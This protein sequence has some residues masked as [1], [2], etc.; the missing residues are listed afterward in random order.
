[1]EKKTTCTKCG[2]SI[3]LH[4]A[5]QYDRLCQACSD[6]PAL[7]SEGLERPAGR[8]LDGQ[9]IRIEKNGESKEYADFVFCTD[10]RDKD[11]RYRSRSMRVGENRGLLR[12][13]KDNGAIEILY[14]MHED[15]D[16]LILSR[17]ALVLL[18]HWKSGEYPDETSFQ[19]G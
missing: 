10:V 2:C 9:Y 13:Y 11:P 8:N 6:R 14:P 7:N 1:M 4:T 15:D 12:L 19:C 16:E 5:Y 3:S 18:K 17:A